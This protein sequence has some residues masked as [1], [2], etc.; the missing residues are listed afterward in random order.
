VQGGCNHRQQCLRKAHGK[1][2]KVG[3]CCRAYSSGGALM[4]S[5]KVCKSFNRISFKP[6]TVWAA[7][8]SDYCRIHAIRIA[9]EKAVR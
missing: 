7:K 2:T 4:P 5:K 9:Q 3:L 6:C 8:G 1:G